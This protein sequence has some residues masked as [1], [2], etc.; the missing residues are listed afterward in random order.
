MLTPKEMHQQDSI[1]IKKWNKKYLS[2]TQRG[3]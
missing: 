3:A 2:A 1:Q